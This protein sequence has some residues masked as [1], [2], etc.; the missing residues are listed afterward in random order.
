VPEF[1]YGRP[2]SA[3]SCRITHSRSPSCQHGSDWRLARL[4]QRGPASSTVG[5]PC[6]PTVLRWEIR[7]LRRDPA[8]WAVLIFGVV[9]LSF[10]LFNGERWRSHLDGLRTAVT[11]RAVSARM[12][13]RELATRIDSGEQPAPFFDG[14]PRNPLAYANHL[15]AHY[16]ILPA[17]RSRLLRLGRVSLLPST[18]PLPP[19]GCPH[20]QALSEPENPHRLLIGRS[21]PPSPSSFCCRC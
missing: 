8:F 7:A 1:D 6:S 21:T 9:A 12:Q 17:P 18:L 5:T 2:A 16:A 13:A 10:A 15:M 4:D 20:L 14:D 11:E 3:G 19:G